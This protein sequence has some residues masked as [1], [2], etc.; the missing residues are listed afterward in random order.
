MTALLIHFCLASDPVWRLL[1]ISDKPWVF[2]IASV[3]AQVSY[4]PQPN[5]VSE[6]LHLSGPIFVGMGAVGGVMPTLGLVVPDRR[7]PKLVGSAGIEGV[8]TLFN[9][10]IFVLPIIVA[11]LEIESDVMVRGSVS[12][13]FVV[14]GRQR[15]GSDQV[16]SV[17]L[18][19]I[20]QGEA[21]QNSAF[22]NLRWTFV[23]DEDP[24]R[25]AYHWPG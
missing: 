19:W 9:A 5:T 18:G 8:L 22:I 6:T 14:F 17:G 20:G 11:S 2:P 21:P 25:P 23:R 13:E 24:E 3:N 1:P 7:A 12:F 10:V 16:L 4:G 15:A